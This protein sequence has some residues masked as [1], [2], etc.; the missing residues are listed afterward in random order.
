M[1]VFAQ[2]THASVLASYD[3]VTVQPL[4]DDVFAYCCREA[5]IDAIV[6]DV[7]A[8]RL[9]YS[10]KR[11][12]V[13]AAVKRGVVLEVSCAPLMKEE[14]ERQRHARALAK[15]LVSHTRGRGIALLSGARDVSAVLS[16]EALLALAG[17]LGSP[18][19]AARAMLRQTA[20]DGLT[21]AAIRRD[22]RGG[23]EGELS[24]SCCVAA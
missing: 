22:V 13:T 17:E 14:S 11:S 7:A 15:K 16:E 9:P 8:G 2:S 6:I 1:H 12:H 21:R 18:P 19:K 5:A 23:V 20:V 3:W 4:N 24:L 10:L